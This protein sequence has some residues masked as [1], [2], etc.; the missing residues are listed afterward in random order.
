MRGSLLVSIAAVALLA[1]CG[2][3]AGGDVV[4][5]AGAADAVKQ[6][7]QAMLQ[8]MKSRNAAKIADY[9]APD[10]AVI[11]PGDNPTEGSAAIAK[12]YDAM[13]A[14]QAFSIDLANA[15]T[16]VAA[17][18]DLAYTRG[19]YRV[20]FTNPGSRQPVTESGNYVTIYKKQQDGGWKIIEDITAP[21]F[22][23]GAGAVPPTSG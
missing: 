8:D 12:R 20:T 15:R 13:L 21:G 18:G 22:P 17:S 2:R 6:V 3:G 11:F 23:E 1:A 4:G 19:T 14:D 9:Y 7:E 5:D 16:S 10:A